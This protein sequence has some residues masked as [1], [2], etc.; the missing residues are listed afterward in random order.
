MPESA[1]QGVRLDHV[2]HAVPRWQDAWDRYATDLGAEWNSGGPGP[3]FAPGQ[4]RF[5]NDA[6]LEILMPNDPQVNDFLER[7]LRSSGPGPHHLTFKVPNLTDAIDH[8]RAAGFEPVG[9]SRTDP[10]WMEAFLHPKVASGVVVQLAEAPHPWSSPPPDDYPTARRQRREGSGPVP[11]AAL[12]RVVHAVADLEQATRLFVGLLGADV[13]GSGERPDHRWMDL[14]WR[15]PL[16]LRLVG[17]RAGQPSTPLEQWLRGRSGR[18]HHLE[19][20]VEEPD[21]VGGTVSGGIATLGLDAG[22]SDR[23]YWVIGPEANLGL[24][25]MLAAP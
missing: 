15:G 11:P 12:R 6:R 7:Y 17:P 22:P 4:L 2:A 19:F 10:E 1:I 13:D 18:I 24:R 9:I 8:C 20:E 3:G 16:S 23:P 14:D 21:A 5:G 25:L